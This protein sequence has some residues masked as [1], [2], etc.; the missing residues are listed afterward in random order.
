MTK[1]TRRASGRPKAPAQEAV[2]E[3]P[4]M[5]AP[6]VSKEVVMEELDKPAPP[7]QLKKKS[8]LKR[9]VRETGAAEYMIP[10]KAGIV[11]MLPQKGVTIYDAE[12]DSIREIRYC[13]NEPSIYVDEQ[14]D[15]ALKQSVVFRDKRLFVRKEQPNLKE[16]MEKHPMNMSNG[17]TLFKIED[18]KADAALSL[19]K[20]FV[21]ND[22]ITMVRDKD[23][24]ELLPV[25]IYFGIN[26]NKPV[27]EIRYNLLTTAK[28]NPKDFIDAFDN[29][30]VRTRSILQQGSDYQLIK[31]KKDGVYW[32]DSNGL[33]VSVPVGQ[34]P[35]DVLVRF[36]MTERGS[37]VISSLEDRLDRLS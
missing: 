19:N 24:Q 25:A 35:M 18:K 33:I 31:I 29:P 11:Y 1:Q 26:I 12:K 27:S 34:D 3:S 13:P 36:C 32:F 8:S 37:S 9:E 4:V 7:P 5:E 2:V 14:S 23:I 10:G 17:G 20:E 22:A 21:L 16:F 6:T 28:K 30:K 15:N